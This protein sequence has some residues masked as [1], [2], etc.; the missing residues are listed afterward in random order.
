MLILDE[1]GNQ[2]EVLPKF[3]VITHTFIDVNG[4][5]RTQKFVEYTVVGRLRQWQDWCPLDVF[6]RLNPEVEV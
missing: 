6:R 5:P 1:N 3:K 4:N 2:R